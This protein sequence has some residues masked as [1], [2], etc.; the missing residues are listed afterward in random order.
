MRLTIF[1]MDL[2]GVVSYTTPSLHANMLTSN[3]QQSAVNMFNRYLTFLCNDL[4]K[5]WLGG[6]VVYPLI[7]NCL[8]RHLGWANALE[9]APLKYHGAILYILAL[10]RLLTE[11]HGQTCVGGSVHA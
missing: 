11:T 9:P 6:V 10:A 7:H 1:G 3:G 5:P 4:F 2:E 8:G